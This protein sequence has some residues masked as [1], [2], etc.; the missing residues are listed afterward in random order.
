MKV[1]QQSSCS[2]RRRKGQSMMLRRMMISMLVGRSVC[3]F[4]PVRTVGST[5]LK[6]MIMSQGIIDGSVGNR[7]N[8]RRPNTGTGS[9]LWST[10]S[11]TDLDKMIEDKGNE[12]RQFK[13]D[14]MNKEDLAPHIQELL[15]LKEQ[16]DGPPAAPQNQQPK[17]TQTSQ[18]EQKS[19]FICPREEDYSRWY[20]DVIRVTGMAE[21]SPVRGS[22]IIKPWGMAVWEAVKEDLNRRIVER[23][24]DNVYF[25]LLIPKQFLSQEADHVEGF[26][27]ECAVIT[28][29]RLTFDKETGELVED[30]EAKLAEPLIIRPTSETMIWNT[31]RDWIVSWRDLPLKVNQWANVMRW[32]LRTRPFLRTSEFLWQ[33]GHTAH[34]TPECARQEAETMIA[35][36]QQLCQEVLAMPTVVGAKSPR[37]RFAGAEETYTIEALLPNGWALQSGTSHYLGQSFGKAFDVTYQTSDETTELVYGTSWGVSTRLIGALIM[38]HSD[39]QGLVLPPKMAPVQV[40]IVPLGNPN[41]MSDQEKTNMQQSLDTITSQ[42]KQNNIKF[43]IDDR[44]YVRPGAKYFEWERKGVP[45][46]LELGPRDLANKS[47]ILAYR[48]SNKDKQVVQL[49]NVI[50]TIQQDLVEIQDQ[51]Y[52]AAKQRLEDGITIDTENKITYQNLKDALQNDEASSFPGSGLY[53]LPWN[54]NTENEEAI[55]SDC[56]AT[57]RCYPTDQQHLAKGKTCFYS[58]KP[59]T[60]MALFGR[61]F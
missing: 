45:I 14:G 30:P 32:E 41:K 61:A 48:L 18:D 52:Q 28:H 11:G 13:A 3:G 40:I 60:H 39:N 46:R 56:K 25:P 8:R 23:G 37:E 55:Q 4:S 38:T 49:E 54:C 7:R 43:K 20:Q 9:M 26:A 42:L 17:K 27:K 33:E 34:A 57:I 12:I 29:H 35:V 59:A 51:L 44:D 21:N 58:G 22:M 36:Y 24:V 19:D 6:S 53:L 2:D 16:R 47:C 10:S 5:A 50:S 1:A 31:F 15:R